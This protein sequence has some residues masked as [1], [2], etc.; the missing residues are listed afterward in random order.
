MDVFTKLLSA[1]GSKLTAGQR[2][3]LQWNDGSVCCLVDPKGDHLYCVVTAA[4][5]YPERLAYQLLYDLQASVSQEEDLDTME[6]DEL[7]VKFEAKLKDLLKHYEDKSNFPQ[8]QRGSM[9][10]D[11]ITSANSE[12]TGAANQGGGW[13][14]LVAVAVAVLLIGVLLFSAWR[15]VLSGSASVKFLAVAKSSKDASHQDISNIAH[16]ASLMKAVVAKT[17]GPARS[18]ISM[19]I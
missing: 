3:R 1:A 10:R 14:R 9:S 12:E 4:M 7:M 2:T 11:S 5:S 17:L 8:F 6:E 16:T 18:V 15:F 13:S 19:M